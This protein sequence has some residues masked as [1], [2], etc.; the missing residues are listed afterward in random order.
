MANVI[1]VAKKRKVVCE[2]WSQ[3]LVEANYQTVSC[4]TTTDAVLCQIRE[5]K[6][7]LLL[8]EAGFADGQGF[9]TARRS[10][11][12]HPSLR[13]IMALLA[14][15]TYYQHSLQ[16]DIS[17]YLP[18]DMDD[19][20]ELL[21]CIDQIGQ[22]YR[23]ISEVFWGALRFPSDQYEQLIDGLSERRKQLLKLLAKGLTARQIAQEM[24]IAE[25]TVRHHKEEIS[26]LLGLPGT[27][28]LKI[29]AGSVA[30]LLG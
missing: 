15:T 13:C 7:D 29:F 9:E 21:R 8:I 11:T 14:G 24:K 16:T 5:S 27:Y 18:E 28:Q 2:Y 4:W 6:P 20:G 23:Y 25:P 12:A 10:I 26:K 19:P 22:G 3:V 30:H 17:G 1:L